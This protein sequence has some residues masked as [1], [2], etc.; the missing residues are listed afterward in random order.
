MVRLSRLETASRLS[1]SAVARVAR[2][3]EQ[4]CESCLFGRCSLLRCR[5]NEGRLRG[6]SSHPSGSRRTQPDP[7]R[8]EIGGPYQ[9]PERSAMQRSLTHLVDLLPHPST[10]VDSQ[11]SMKPRSGE[12]TADSSLRSRISSRCR[13]RQGG[14]CPRTDDRSKRSRPPR[15]AYRLSTR[16]APPRGHRLAQR[17]L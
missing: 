15:E 6:V 5:V 1:L 14:P 17:R 2:W 9:Q 4:P 10:S 8:D 7:L 3:Y 11:V 12:L 13:L 16:P